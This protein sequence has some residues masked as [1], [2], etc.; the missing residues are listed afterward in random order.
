LGFYRLQQSFSRGFPQ[1]ARI[2]GDQHVR[3]RI[4]AFGLE[5]REQCAFLIGDELDS[6]AALFR[7]SV[8][9]GFDEL[10]YPG[11]VNDYLLGMGSTGAKPGNRAEYGDK[12]IFE[13]GSR[14]FLLPL[15]YAVICLLM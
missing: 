7:E 4:F 3:R 13:T 5:A 14:H 8:K 1:I 15:A 11:G 6:E 12:I 2:H 10:F 9:H